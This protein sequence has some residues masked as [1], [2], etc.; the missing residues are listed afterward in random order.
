M[1]AR[2]S[3]LTGAETVERY[4]RKLARLRAKRRKLRKVKNE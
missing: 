1:L 3:K 2:K 4:K